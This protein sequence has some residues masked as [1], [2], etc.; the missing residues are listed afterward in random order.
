MD[1]IEG[2]DLIWAGK[3]SWRSTVSF[4][5]GWAAIGAV[6]LAAILLVNGL[7]DTSWSAGLGIAI[8]V[9]VFALA[10]LVGWIRRYFTQYTITTKRI[11][12]RQGVLAK[13]EQTA[14]IDR[15]QNVTIT[16]SPF[17]RLFRVGMLDFDT[18]GVDTDAQLRFLG[19]NDPQ[20]LRERLAS[21]LLNRGP[22]SEPNGLR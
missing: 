3:P 20:A 12:I 6:P 5:L 22:D 19:I 4:Y 14:H 10:V 2:E 8:L 13:R 16:Q 21:E 9:I 11:T 17:D 18:A 1:L 7:T 15:V